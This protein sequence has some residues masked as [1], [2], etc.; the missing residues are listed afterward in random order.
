MSVS[1]GRTST[2]R[3]SEFAALDDPSESRVPRAA[4]A[5]HAC[6]RCTR[7]TRGRRSESGELKW[8]VKSREGLRAPKLVI[9]DSCFATP[10]SMLGSSWRRIRTSRTTKQ[11]TSSEREFPY[12]SPKMPTESG[13]WE[14][15]MGCVRSMFGII[16]SGISRV[17]AGHHPWHASTS[18]PLVRLVTD[19]MFARWEPR[20]KQSS[21]E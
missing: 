4:L 9:L 20:D 15:R 13:A 3:R 19:I 7:N 5:K 18:R 1:T 14:D 2:S 21:E 17:S 16:D 11:G 10:A 6:R 8:A 12:R